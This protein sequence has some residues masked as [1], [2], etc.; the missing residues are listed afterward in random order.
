M[1]KFFGTVIFSVF[2]FSVAEPFFIYMSNPMRGPILILLVLMFSLIIFTSYLDLGL[3]AGLVLTVLFIAIFAQPFSVAQCLTES[4]EL[5]VK[6]AIE[7]PEREKLKEYLKPENSLWD[8]E[9]SW[10]LEWCK[11]R[12]D[13][14]KEVMRLIGNG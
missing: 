14:V 5:S 8:T 1:Q 9:D 6:A 13:V 3:G 7:N 2:A 4:K 12:H 10:D 11:K